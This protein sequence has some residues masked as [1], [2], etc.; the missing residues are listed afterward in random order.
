MG[1][2]GSRFDKRNKL[3]GD[4]N[5][6]GLQFVGGEANVSD[7]CPMDKIALVFGEGKEFADFLKVAGL[8]AS[9]EEVATK[10]AKDTYKALQD[11]D[12]FLDKEYGA[13]KD[14]KKVYVGG[15]HD[16]KDAKDQIA[17]VLAH[18]KEKSGIEFPAEEEKKEEG[19]AE[20]KKEEGGEEKKEEGGEGAENEGGEE[21]AAEE[22]EKGMDEMMAE[23]AA[24]ADLYK[25]DAAD[26]AGWENLPALF[27]RNMVVNPYF[28]DLVKGEVI[29]WEFN[30]GKSEP[31]SKDWAPV[32]SLVGAA[33]NSGEAEEKEVFF[34]GYLGEEDHASLLGIAEIKGPI[35]FPGVTSGWASE[36]EALDAIGEYNGKQ[37]A[38][39]VVYKTKTK[40]L[41]AVVC[42]H[43]ASRF[44]A[45]VEKLEEKDGVVHV[46]LADKTPEAQTI[47][48]WKAAVA[49]AAK[50]AVE[51]AAG[52]EEEK[53]EGE[54]EKKEGEEEKKEGEEEEK[55][56]GE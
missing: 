3:A 18:L 41:S 7:L 27:L 33:V 51:G 56:E 13:P 26:Y 15:K 45:Q 24:A 2:F 9:D 40:V 5:T 19:A 43:F 55:K 48:E 53:K 37:N 44:A 50:K 36:K 30:H 46:E 35:L 14:G 22:G 4:L 1:C 38:K 54:E 10:I 8:K 6:V 32:A 52:K 49:E 20:E 17:A 23:M 29:A 12:K 28:G 11:H 25:D 16:L 34:S 39:K 21:G 47:E 42:R 31:K